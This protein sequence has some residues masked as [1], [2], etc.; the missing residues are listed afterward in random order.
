MGNLAMNAILRHK[1]TLPGQL[2]GGSQLHDRK[3]FN[4]TTVNT[5]MKKGQRFLALGRLRIIFLR[6]LNE[7]AYDMKK[8]TI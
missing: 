6:Q 2:V 5:H 3:Q 4:I 1:L 7:G 8:K